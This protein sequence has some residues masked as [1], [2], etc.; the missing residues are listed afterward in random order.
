M[1]CSEYE[2]LIE[3]HKAGAIT[4]EERKRL[5]SH[6]KE[7][8]ECRTLRDGGILPERGRV[9]E[10]VK[11]NKSKSLPVLIAAVLIF[12]L[13]IIVVIVIRNQVRKGS[14][15]A[16]EKPKLQQVDRVLEV[17]RVPGVKRD[18]PIRFGKPGYEVPGDGRV[19]FELKD[20]S[21][22]T[23]YRDTSLSFDDTPEG[24]NTDVKRGRCE[25]RFKSGGRVTV[26]EALVD[27]GGETTVQVNFTD[28]VEIRILLGG[29]RVTR[30]GKSRAVLEG[31]T[32]TFKPGDSRTDIK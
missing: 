21:R 7:C 26:G 20:G 15:A 17:L 23:A 32:F 16:S 2:P 11:K 12:V 18:D 25:F 3:K 27:A 31:S 24:L 10:R 4:E 8:F 19:I 1:A 5:D 29:A 22:V 28:K 9:R 14:G 30:G 6:T 13:V